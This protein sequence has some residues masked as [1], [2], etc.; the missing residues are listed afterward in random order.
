MLKKLFI[1]CLLITGIIVSGGEKTWQKRWVYVPS[2]LYVD[3]NVPKLEKLFSRAKNAGFNG[4]L[5]T[6]YKI[7]TWWDLEGAKRWQKNAEQLRAI[8]KKLDLELVICVF[9]FGY[10]GSLLWHDVNLASGIPVK[11][12]PLIAK[13]GKLVLETTIQVRNGSFEE[14]KNHKAV[15]FAFQDDPGKGSFIDEKVFKQGKVSLRFDDVGQANKHGHGR[16]CQKIKVKP[17]QQY[18]IRVWMKAKNLT[19]SEI[20]ILVLGNN[21]CLQWQYPSVQDGKNRR[22]NNS[23]RNLTTDWVEQSV[24]F[25]SFENTEVNVYLGLWGGKTGSI[26]WDDLRIDDVP[27]LNVLRRDSLPLTVNGENGKKYLEGKDYEKIVDQKLG[28]DPWPGS[29]DTSHDPPAIRLTK[30]S[31]IKQGEKVRLS[32]YNTALVHGGQVNCSMNDPKVFQ[33]CRLQMQK[34]REALN[35]D[36][37]FM[38]HDEIR[39]AGW[40]PDQIK[41][42]KSSGE[43]FAFN[44]RKCYEIAAAE[45]KGKPIYLWSDMYDPNHNAHTDFY[46]VNNTIAGSWEGLDPKIIIMKWGGGKIAQPGLKFFADRGHKQMIAAYYDS[47]VQNDHKMWTEAAKD[48]P[49]IIGVMYTTWHNDYSNLEKFAETWWGGGKSEV[50]NP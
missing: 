40:E 39:C 37:Y 11:D 12:A 13:D 32:C 38:S 28:K 25:N 27:A 49:G 45:S 41:R 29:Y 4:I 23:P 15:G 10:A 47:N 46:L 44:I 7:L 26:W 34:T 42:F 50:T 21:R 24:T 30:N 20:K 2:N 43:L 9:P 22:Y 19:A 5:F 35:P 1:I 6:D 8:S 17:W 3:S 16:I 33:L 14:Y 31:A 18:R 48:I 36:G